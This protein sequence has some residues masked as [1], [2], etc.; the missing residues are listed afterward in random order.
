MTS[1]LRSMWLLHRIGHAD[2]ADEQGCE[3]DQRQE[4]REAGDVA[5]KLRRGIVAGADFPSRLRICVLS[6]RLGSAVGGSDSSRHPARRADRSSAPGCRAATDPV[7]RSA[8]SLTR[9]RGPNPTPPASLSGSEPQHGTDFECRAADGDAIAEFQIEP[10]QKGCIACRAVDVVTN[11]ERLCDRH[12]WIERDRAEQRIG[13]VDG[14]QFDQREAAVSRAGHRAHGRCDRDGA[15]L[16]DRG[17]LVLCCL[18]LDQRQRDIAAEDDAA[19]ARQSIGKAATRP[20]RRRQSQRRRARCR[21]S[22]RKIRAVRR[23]ARATHSAATAAA[24]YGES[25][26]ASVTTRQ[27][28]TRDPARDLRSC[29]IAAE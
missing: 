24:A 16:F 17:A 12:C 5:F 4:L 1:R 27:P 20:S 11:R 29:R 6:Q 10:C 3:A 2:A 13:A 26:A 23:A 14:F 15:E 9:K 18:A 7:A 28:V 22:R 8:S 21:R 25:K 19:F